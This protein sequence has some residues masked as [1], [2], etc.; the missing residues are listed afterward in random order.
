MWYASEAEAEAAIK[1]MIE[2]FIEDGLEGHEYPSE[3]S[4][5]YSN[6]E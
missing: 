5:L 2:E 6:L 1:A 4:F 3:A